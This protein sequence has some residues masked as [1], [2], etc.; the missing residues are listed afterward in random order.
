MERIKKQFDDSH[1]FCSVLHTKNLLSIK[2][3]LTDFDR[4]MDSYYPTTITFN[5]S[6]YILHSTENQI[7]TILNLNI[8]KV[9]MIQ[10]CCDQRRNN[11]HAKT[12]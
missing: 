10:N 12:V 9:T 3:N 11:E 4:T 6:T 7:Q 8:R 1:H 2:T 5:Q